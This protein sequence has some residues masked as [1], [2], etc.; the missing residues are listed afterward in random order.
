MD[1]ARKKK[2][3][4][5]DQSHHE[6][7]VNGDSND[8]SRPAKRSKLDQ[9]GGDGQ[10]KEQEGDE[11]EEEGFRQPVLITGATMKDYQLEGVEWMMGLHM[12]GISGILGES[13]YLFFMNTHTNTYF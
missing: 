1:E 2:R 7:D 13:I 3:L 6:Q 4:K 5:S 12:N 11:E 9:D 10:V 8:T